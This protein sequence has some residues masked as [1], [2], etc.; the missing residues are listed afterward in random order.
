MS[1]NEVTDETYW[2]AV[3]HCLTGTG[4]LQGEPTT[5]AQ[6]RD[7]LR[8]LVVEIE[9]ELFPQDGK[10]CEAAV[11]AG[12]VQHRIHG[13]VRDIEY[14][15]VTLLPK[16]GDA[17][18]SGL[19]K[20]WQKIAFDA[21]HFVDRDEAFNR[22][23][24]DFK[25]AHKLYLACIK[26]KAPDALGGALIDLITDA[27]DGNRN[28]DGEIVEDDDVHF[29]PEQY[30][31]AY[32]EESDLEARHCFL[33]KRAAALGV[34]GLTSEHDICNSGW[35]RAKAEAD[36]KRMREAGRKFERNGDQHRYHELGL[37]ACDMW[38]L[39]NDATGRGL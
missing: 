29:T 17:S 39:L 8:D 38:R 15:A 33:N 37:V 19:D 5:L 10:E 20:R 36:H 2:M 4:D 13:I 6:I 18:R 21:V 32:G 7:D 31:K 3:R 12:F 14:T 27:G 34:E 11:L 35:C 24:Y 1:K 28:A 23:D 9:A 16:P 25:T 22:P 26:S 30:R